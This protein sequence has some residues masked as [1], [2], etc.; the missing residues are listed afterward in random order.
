MTCVTATPERDEILGLLESEA[1]VRSMMHVEASGCWTQRAL[2]AGAF[3]GEGSD[4][5]PVRRAQIWPVR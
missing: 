2:M 3:E 5:E 4:A 1:P